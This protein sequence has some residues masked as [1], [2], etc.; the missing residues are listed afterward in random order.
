MANNPGPGSHEQYGECAKG[1]QVNSM[2]HSIQSPS[3]KGGEKHQPIKSSLS[4]IL[5]GPGHYRP[6]SDFGYIDFRKTNSSMMH[7]AMGKQEDSIMS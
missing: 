6:P 1:V 3:F 4:Y 5:P 2:Y 7:S